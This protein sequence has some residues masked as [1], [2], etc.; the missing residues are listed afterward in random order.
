MELSLIGFGQVVMELSLIGYG[1]VVMELSLI[2]YGQDV[3]V[4]ESCLLCISFMTIH[5]HTSYI[6][7]DNLH[8][9]AFYSFQV[10]PL[11][12]DTPICAD[13][14][15]VVCISDTHT[16]R[17]RYPERVPSG[18][19]LLHAGVFTRHGLTIEVKQFNNFLGT[20]ISQYHSHVYDFITNVKCTT[21]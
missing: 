19:I 12:H 1:Q 15:R 14:L 8:G 2:G 13:M 16:R 6:W 7:N 4:A 11:P 21:I 5:L 3:S 10:K 17:E 9:C 20:R 18:D